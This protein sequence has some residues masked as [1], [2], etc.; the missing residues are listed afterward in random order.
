MSFTL[1][2]EEVACGAWDCV[3]ER[4]SMQVHGRSFAKP[5]KLVTLDEENENFQL[6]TSERHTVQ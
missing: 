5:R 3:S 1:P 6:E 2:G 4:T